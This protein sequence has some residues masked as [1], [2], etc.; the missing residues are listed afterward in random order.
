MALHDEL[1]TDEKEKIVKHLLNKCNAANIKDKIDCTP[2]HRAIMKDST[3]HELF[4]EI[5][6]RFPDDVNAQDDEGDTPLMVAVFNESTAKVKKL[7]P[8]SNVNVE[9]KVGYIALHYAATWKNVPVDLFDEII[10]KSADINAQDNKG[11]T[12]LN[13]ALINE[14]VT[15]AQQL[16]IKGADVNVKNKENEKAIYYAVSWTT[17]PHDLI[18]K[19]VEKTEG[20]IDSALRLA[21]RHKLTAVIKLLE[22][23]DA[24]VSPGSEQN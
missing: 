13:R 10:D 14:S 11:H 21:R 23:K 18:Q 3:T 8:C 22:E 1:N 16:L 20:N 6:K 2:L 9:N 19:I 15:A 17:I 12:P 7:L 4:Q 5:L 24:T